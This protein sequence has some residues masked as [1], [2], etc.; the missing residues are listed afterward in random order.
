MHMKRFLNDVTAVVAVEFAIIAPVMLVCYFGLAEVT[1][2]MICQRRISHAS[3][4]IGDLVAQ[5][6]TITK[7]EVQDVFTVA[8]TIVAPYPTAPLEMRISSITAD[9]NRN[10][11]VD[12]SQATNMSP[13]AK[14]AAQS[15]PTTVVSASQ[16]VIEADMVYVYTSPV[17]YFTLNPITFS[18]TYYLKPRIS[19]SVACADC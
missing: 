16:S 7:A 15:V 12:W 3:S 1:Q 19:N 5:S 2:G 8:D 11:T 10:T 14:G 17:N 13:L 18:Y 6:S 9:A 4:T